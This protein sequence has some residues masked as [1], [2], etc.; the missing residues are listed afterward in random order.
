MTDPNAF[1]VAWRMYENAERFSRGMRDLLQIDPAADAEKRA[2]VVRGLLHIAIPD[3]VTATA[4]L[5]EVRDLHGAP[6]VE[7]LRVTLMRALDEEAERR[8]RL[9][10]IARKAVAEYA[11]Q[12]AAATWPPLATGPFLQPDYIPAPVNSGPIA[13]M[14]RQG[15]VA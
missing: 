5:D 11:T 13:L 2:Q 14:R 6:A 7:E 4:V 10:E 15:G 12:N 9:R 8:D 3:R 1:Q